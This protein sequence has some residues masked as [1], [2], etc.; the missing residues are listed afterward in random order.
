MGKSE[1]DLNYLFLLTQNL[2]SQKVTSTTLRILIPVKRPRIPPDRK[3]D[4]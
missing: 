1:K 3:E 4:I 2:I